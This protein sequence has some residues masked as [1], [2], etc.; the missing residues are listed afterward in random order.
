MINNIVPNVNP[1][2]NTAL[3]EISIEIPPKIIYVE[4]IWTAFIL[5][6]N[7]MAKA[8]SKK[9]KYRLGDLLGDLLLAFSVFTFRIF[10]PKSIVFFARISGTMAF[11]LAKKYRDR[12][13]SNLLLAFGQEKDFKEIAKLAKE[14]FFNFTLTPFE[15]ILTAAA[16]SSQFIKEIKIVGREYLD[17]ALAKGNGVIAL[18]GHLGAF[19]TLGTILAKEGYP[20]NIIIKVENFPKIWDR[21]GGYQQRLG[22]K[23]FPPKPATASIKKSLNCLRRN[24][25]LYLIA[26]EQQ[27]LGGVPVPF[28]GQTAYTPPGPAIFSLKTGAPILPMF[29][30]RKNG[31]PQTLFIG[32]PI[33]IELTS[34]E[35]KNTELLTA[36]FTKTIE[37]SIRQYPSQWPWLNR[38]WKQP[39]QKGSLDMGTREV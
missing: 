6:R 7:R 31:I 26:D 11:Y 8:Y 3:P 20:F 13:L 10:P 21:L 1:T 2:L 29:L 5:Y 16:P 17:A 22:Q 30:V 27:I 24:E 33:E 4:G 25:I 23:P 15:I 14:V 34:D 39:Y 36:K 12:V 32:S 38:R 19:T 37:D 35:K 18:G 9:I 28:F